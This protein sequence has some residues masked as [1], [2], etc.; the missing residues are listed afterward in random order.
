MRL[1]RGQAQDRE[2]RGWT[3]LPQSVGAQTSNPRRICGFHSAGAGNGAAARTPHSAGRRQVGTTTVW[4]RIRHRIHVQA[5]LGRSGGVSRQNAG[6]PASPG[7]LCHQP[8]PQARLAQ[9]PARPRLDSRPPLSQHRPRNERVW[10]GGKVA[11]GH[12]GSVPM[13]FRPAAALFVHFVFARTHAESSVSA[14]QQKGQFAH[15]VATPVTSS[16]TY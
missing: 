14:L 7:R 9:T 1:G 12:H 5:Y 6:A 4:L 10:A 8:W 13:E 3:R 11:F 16:Q 15:F 2:R